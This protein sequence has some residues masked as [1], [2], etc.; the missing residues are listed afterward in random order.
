M[1]IIVLLFSSAVLLLAGASGAAAGDEQAAATM[2]QQKCAACHT[3][4]GGRRI[5]PDLRG[6]LERR[7]TDWLVR[8]ITRPDQ[9]LVEKDP[10]A[11]KLLAE[12]NQISMPNLGVTEP[13]ARALLDYIRSASA[14]PIPAA[15]A[16]PPV[17]AVL[18]PP[19]LGPIQRVALVLFLALTAAIIIAFAWVALSTRRPETLDVKRAYALR[20]VFFVVTA[21]V[22]LIALIGTASRTPYNA[23]R[24]RP[25]RII[26]VA[27]QQFGF[28]FSLEPI[29]SMQDLARVPVVQQLE[30]PAGALLEFRVTSLDVNHNFG[31]YGPQRRLL[32]QTQAMPGYVNRLLVRLETPGR[33]EV[34]CL[35]YCGAGH[36][37]M[38]TELTVK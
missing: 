10:V 8:W 37:L 7:Q 4:G 26:Y 3:I 16:A 12:S 38:Q 6:V 35:E 23:A 14:A 33:Y 11:L 36:H 29:V 20:R 34:L 17:A 15:A 13:E 18:A 1:R 32:A 21:T 28:S 24:A 22:L 5:G 30:L 2:F 31:L 9:M 25:D 19:S 27:A